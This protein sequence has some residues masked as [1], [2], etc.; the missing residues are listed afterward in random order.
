M[1]QVNLIRKLTRLLKIEFA[2]G[3]G[4]ERRFVII[5]RPTKHR[6]EINEI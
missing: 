1:M 2:A 3:V 4:F 6:N 5:V